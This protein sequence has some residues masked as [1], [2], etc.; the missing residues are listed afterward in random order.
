ME[1]KDESFGFDFEAIYDQIELGKSFSYSFA[2]RNVAVEFKMLDDQKEAII[3]FDPENENP[4]ELQKDGWQA[5]LNNF[6]HYAEI[7]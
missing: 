2:G 5:I 4:I 7:N 6:K 3:V 1:A